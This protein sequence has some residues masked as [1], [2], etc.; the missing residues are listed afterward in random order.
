MKM[1]MHVDRKN[2]HYQ[3]KEEKITADIKGRLC[4]VRATGRV[5]SNDLSYLPLHVGKKPRPPF[6]SFLVN[7]GYKTYSYVFN[8]QKRPFFICLLSLMFWEFFV[9]TSQK[10]ESLDIYR[11]V[12]RVGSIYLRSVWLFQRCMTKIK[13]E[14]L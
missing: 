14:A 2:G 9:L 3:K 10:Q 8:G 13:L 5:R 1:Q 4:C 11:T 6:S 12:L 7:C